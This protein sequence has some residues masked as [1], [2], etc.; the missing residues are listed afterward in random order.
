[1]C[2]LNRACAASAAVHSES[3]PTAAPSLSL[4]PLHLAS[5][6]APDPLS[7]WSGWP[8]V[9]SHGPRW[10]YRDLRGPREVVLTEGLAGTAAARALKLTEGLGGTAA[11]RALAA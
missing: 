11:A 5:P 4:L 9:P 1:M 8:L 2:N 3:P 7:S 10:C 6:R